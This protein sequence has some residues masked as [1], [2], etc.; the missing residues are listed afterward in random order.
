M[1]MTK[2]NLLPGILSALT[3]LLASASLLSTNAQAEQATGEKPQVVLVTPSEKNFPETLRDFQAKVAEAGWSVLNVNNMA[4]TLSERGFTV[5]PVVIIDV[6][7]GAY[8]HRILSQDD[9]RPTSA[10][11]PCRVSIYQTS[12]GKVFVARMNAG[13]FA[14]M[15]P[16]EVGKV[17]T[18]SD[19]AIGRIID[20]AV[21]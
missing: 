5:A 14:A 2:K 20:S 10:F 18:E 21:R 7:S 6:C 16:E 15:M 1:I 4:G 11:M 3:I 8:S 19:A 17:M 12:E 13:A 9:Y